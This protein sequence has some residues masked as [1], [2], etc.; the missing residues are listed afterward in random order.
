MHGA[1][2]VRAPTKH[3]S[4]REMLVTNIFTNISTYLFCNCL[5]G[6][7]AVQAEA[8]IKGLPNAKVRQSSMDGWYRCGV[9]IVVCVCVCV[10][11]CMMVML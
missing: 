10:W 9:C 3:T 5:C 1:V 11:R 2:R 8:L 4:R 6:H 7:S